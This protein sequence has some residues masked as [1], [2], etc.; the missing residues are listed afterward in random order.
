MPDPLPREW[1]EWFVESFSRAGRQ[2]KSAI[3]KSFSRY[4]LLG[5]VADENGNPRRGQ[6]WEGR[7][8]GGC[9]PSWLQGLLGAGAA[10][11]GRE[12]VASPRSERVA[13]SS[14]VGRVRADA[15]T[16]TSE[17]GLS[18]SSIRIRPT[19]TVTTPSEL[20]GAEFSPSTPRFQSN[21]GSGR[22]RGQFSRIPLSA[23][24]GVLD[25][26]SSRATL[27]WGLGRLESSSICV[28]LRRVAREGGG[29]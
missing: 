16:E 15:R 8:E 29:P 2:Q 25:S 5:G 7:D 17:A 1:F 6:D 27:I 11:C 10:T 24:G 3:R 26:P 19:P 21:L 23:E 22:R 18:G 9:S 14:G 12:G 13:R 20:G 28:H 4:K